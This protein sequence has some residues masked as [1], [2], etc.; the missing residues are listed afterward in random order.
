MR[1]PIPIN[2]SDSNLLKRYKKI[3]HSTYLFFRG[4]SC[5]SVCVGTND[6]DDDDL[7]LNI[8]CVVEYIQK[9]LP[10]GMDSIY[11][12]GLKAQNSPNLPIYKS[13]A[14]IVHEEQD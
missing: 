1:F 12:M 3:L 9:S 7:Y 10:G 11:T 5:C 6:M 2:L 8:H 4:G 13:G 14:M